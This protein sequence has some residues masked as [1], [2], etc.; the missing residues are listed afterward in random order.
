[1]TSLPSVTDPRKLGKRTTGRA[2]LWE[3]VQASR[4]RSLVV[5][6]SKD[7]NAKITVLLVSPRGHP[8]YAIKAPTTDLAAGAVEAEARVLA[9]FETLLPQQLGET[10]PRVVGTVEF[11]GRPAI[12][13]TAVHG[14]PMST[15]Y[16]QRRHTA[17]AARVA[18]DFAAAERWLGEFQ[19]ATAQDGAKSETAVAS[20]L[21]ER[22]AEDG[23]LD[24]DL[25]C[26]AEI[27][28]RLRGNAG[29]CAAVHGD[30]WFGNVLL[31]EGRVSG[32]VDW[33]A[34]GH[35]G[36]PLRDVVRFALMYALY[37]DSRTRRGRTIAGHRGLRAD[38]WGAGVQFALNG[39]GWFPNL[40]R[41]FLRDGLARLGAP[42]GLWREAALAGIAEI[43]AVTDNQEF[44]RRQLELFRRVARRRP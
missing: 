39:S 41:R 42:S 44:A 6:V 36:E 7:P 19:R 23:Q 40:F 3:F 38:E 14:S 12:V 43:A 29:L 32:V 22:F 31:S 26:L 10:V 27:D 2:P 28:A 5:G 18:A 9:R 33:E 16:L 8:V 13:M 1:M 11:R 17:S 20:R 24:A 4:L 21:R 30:F 35:A 37:L 25:E 34:G 15:S